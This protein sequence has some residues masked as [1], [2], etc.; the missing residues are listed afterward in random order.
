MK[1][2][3]ESIPTTVAPIAK[4]EAIAD[5][6]VLTKVRLPDL[7]VRLLTEVGNGGFG[8]GHGLMGVAGGARDTL[9]F[10]IAGRFR[11]F[12]DQHPDD[13]TWKW[14]PRLVPI[15]ELGAGAY[16]CLDG[17]KKDAMPMVLFDPNPRQPDEPWDQCFVPLAPTLATWLEAWLEGNDLVDAARKKHFGEDA[18]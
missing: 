13:R 7:L 18:W 9:R 5:A 6:E 16:A 12:V 14:P 8:P 1:L 3:R 10:G 2:G 15:C 17:S 11:A 4:P